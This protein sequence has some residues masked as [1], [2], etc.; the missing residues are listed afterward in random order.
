VQTWLTSDLH[1]FHE[2]IIVY[3]NRGQTTVEEMNDHII[4]AWNSTVKPG[5]RAIVVG[6]LS[7]SLRDRK[8]QLAQII[9]DLPGDKILVRGNHDHQ[10]DEWYIAAGFTLVTDWLF[11]DG[12]LFVHKPANQHNADAIRARDEC[13][14]DLIVHGHIHAHGPEIPGHFNVAWDRHGRLI[15]LGEIKRET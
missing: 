15:N 7:A 14:P 4:S 8:E 6:D 12:L 5:D 1:L 11:E 9:H 3:C 2:N 10:P 13:D